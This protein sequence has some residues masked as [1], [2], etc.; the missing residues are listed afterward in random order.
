MIES[1]TTPEQSEIDRQDEIDTLDNEISRVRDQ[2]SWLL[3]FGVLGMF[4]S[5]LSLVIFVNNSLSSGTFQ[6][7]YTFDIAFRTLLLCLFVIWSIT[8]S[9]LIYCTFKQRELLAKRYFISQ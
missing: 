3:M 6:I 7:E 5:I 2:A 4:T 8:G 9:L 1:S